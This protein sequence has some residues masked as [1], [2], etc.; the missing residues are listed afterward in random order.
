MDYQQ[1]SDFLK[2]NIAGIVLLGAMSSVLS[3]I[4]SWSSVKFYRFF[5]KKIGKF[6]RKQY[7]GLGYM[8]AFSEFGTQRHS[9]VFASYVSSLIIKSVV[10]CSVFLA[11]TITSI[12]IFVFSVGFSNNISLVGYF[13]SII[14]LSVGMFFLLISW[15]D[16]K[17]LY[18]TS[19][20]VIEELKRNSKTRPKSTQPQDTSTR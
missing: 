6:F 5:K 10:N 13:I 7:F 11:F 12:I 16:Y 19:F 9:T 1:I 20:L 4:I 3:A 2:N 18:A 14:F 8:S 15:S 17:A